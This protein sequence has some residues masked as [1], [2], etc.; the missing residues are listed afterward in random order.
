MLQANDKRRKRK[1]IDIDAPI[2]DKY[3]TEREKCLPCPRV[4]CAP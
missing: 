1:E 4:W 3:D 2:V